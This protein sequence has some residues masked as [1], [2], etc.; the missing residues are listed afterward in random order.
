M[1]IQL[2]IFNIET[3]MTAEQ[4]TVA[5]YARLHNKTVTW[6][7]KQIRDK[8]VNGYRIGGTGAWVIEL[9]GEEDK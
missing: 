2:L 3:E 9:N 5:Q 4:I 7:M 6:A 8:K 1:H